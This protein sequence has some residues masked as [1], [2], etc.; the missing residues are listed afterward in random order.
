M[1]P[2]GRGA[3]RDEVVAAEM[4]DN[5]WMTSTPTQRPP[6]ADPRP[7]VGERGRAAPTNPDPRY[8]QWR[9]EAF[10]DGWAPDEEPPPPLRT[11]VREESA[12]TII[13]RNDS[14]D[15]PFGQT[16]N[17]YRGCEHGCIYCYARPSHAYLDL[18]PG[19]DFESKLTAKV[20]APALLEAELRRP[21]YRCAP[22][23]IGLNTDAY[24]P[25]ERHYRIT[26]RVL[27]ILTAFRHPFALVTK[28]SL[29]E[30]DLDLIAPM[31]REGLAT[32]CISLT[33]LDH[34]L[35][36][37][38][39]PR[40]AAPRRRLESI[41]R[42][43]DAGVEVGLLVSPQIP[44]LNDHELEAVMEAAAEAG[45][46]RAR[47]QTVR[48]P[49][50]VGALFEQ[51]LERHYPLKRERVISLIRQLHQG[52]LNDSRSGRRMRGSGPHA[53]LIAQRVRLAARR[54][55]LTEEPPPL[56]TDRFRPPPRTGDQM[57]LF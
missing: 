56:A 24:Q 3:K 41:A 36:R 16:V 14:D 1:G 47:Y 43:S 53:Q 39:E 32:V 5:G 35:A 21:G 4:S 42:L 19:L 34:E 13:S 49:E 45:A 30:R 31:A 2:V 10:D 55:G 9:R 23:G 40:A 6:L 26:R 44:G 17:P 25:I 15:V 51:W 46:R 7:G 38:L 12:R 37:R 18:S 11:E 22:L 54:L 48:L 33:T 57:G 27:E 28:S 8:G 52:A 50:E 29:V 20:N